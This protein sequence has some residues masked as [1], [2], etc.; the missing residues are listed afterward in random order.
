MD[1]L[2]NW[3][4]FFLISW[5]KCKNDGDIQLGDCIRKSEIRDRNLHMQGR[6]EMLAICRIDNVQNILYVCNFVRNILTCCEFPE[7]KLLDFRK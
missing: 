7:V 6:N 4:A 2:N 1:H 5:R 3:Q